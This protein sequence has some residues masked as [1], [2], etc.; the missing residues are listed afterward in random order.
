MDLVAFPIFKK[1]VF[2]HPGQKLNRKVWRLLSKNKDGILGNITALCQGSYPRNISSLDHEMIQGICWKIN[3]H[4]EAAFR[5]YHNRITDEVT[6]Y[7]S[8]TVLFYILLSRR[9][10]MWMRLTSST[11][12]MKRMKINQA[13]DFVD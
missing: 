10:A 8:V 2:F 9:N 13:S 4:Q 11:G 7:Q 6:G 3:P 1:S 12:K 5:H